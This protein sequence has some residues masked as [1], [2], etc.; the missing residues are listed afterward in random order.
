MN[1]S[2]ITIIRKTSF[3]LTDA[4][5][6]NEFVNETRFHNNLYLASK[7]AKDNG[8]NLQIGKDA[9]TSGL[10][11]YQYEFDKSLKQYSL[12]IDLDCVGIDENFK[13]EA[14]AMEKA[15]RVIAILNAIEHLRLVVKGN[16]DN[17]E[18]IFIVGGIGKAKTHY[19]E[20]VVRTEG[21]NLD[22]TPDLKDRIKQ[23]YGVALLQGGNFS[24]EKAIIEELKPL[25]IS[26][27]FEQLRGQVKYYYGV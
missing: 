18:P 17:A 19:F 7:Y 5:S 13:A 21:R 10:M 1:T 25:S 4:V 14:D 9:D 8:L 3:Y 23:G 15:D 12:T 26:A 22:L 11:P 16:L 20:N 27:F 2:D 6:C 24:N